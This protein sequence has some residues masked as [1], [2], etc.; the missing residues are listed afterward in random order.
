MQ[1]IFAGL[2]TGGKSVT[3]PAGTTCSAAAAAAAR[4]AR[5]SAASPP[6]SS[7]SIVGGKL[8]STACRSAIPAAVCAPSRRSPLETKV[9][10]LKRPPCLGPGD[11]GYA[12]SRGAL[13]NTPQHALRRHGAVRT[14][15]VDGAIPLSA[16]TPEGAL[17][18]SSRRE[19][20]AAFEAHN[21]G[22]ESE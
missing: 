6:C 10:S 3:P 16:C 2:G 5:A 14:E 7:S 18:P 9:Q 19:H 20:A 8:G 1:T 4:R 12:S 11:Q 13:S 15:Q 21:R 22:T 17:A